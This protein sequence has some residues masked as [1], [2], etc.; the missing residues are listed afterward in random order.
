MSN[1]LRFIMVIIIGAVCTACIS[2]FVSEMISPEIGKE[3]RILLIPIF[4]LYAL[5]Y[6]KKHNSTK[7]TP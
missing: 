4:V 1:I 2:I 7:P 3:V 5:L 6:L